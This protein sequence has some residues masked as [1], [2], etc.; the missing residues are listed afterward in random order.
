MK[1]KI[2]SFLEENKYA[3]IVLAALATL[4]IFIAGI[5]SEVCLG[6]ENLHYRLAKSIFCFRKIISVDPAYSQM[7]VKFYYNW[8][9]LWHVVLAF[10]WKLFGKTSFFLA[11]LYQSVYYFFLVVFT[12]LFSCQ[13][14]EKKAA[15]YAALLTA[16]IPMIVSFSILFYLDVPATTFAVLCAWLIFN[17]R[18]FLGGITIVLSYLL[19]TN[20]FLFVPVYLMWLL[21]NSKGIVAKIKNIFFLFLPI[22]LLGSA[23]FFWQKNPAFY[24]QIITNAIKRIKYFNFA[25]LF[26][27]KE[28]NN[29]YLLNPIDIIKY[30]GLSIISLIFLNLFVNKPYKKYSRQRNF[31]YLLLLFYIIG[32]GII[33][34]FYTDIRY[35]LPISP[36]LAMLVAEQFFNLKQKTKFIII[37]LCFMQVLSVSFYV[38]FQRRISPEVKEGFIFLKENLPK[39]IGVIYPE[40]AMMLE[41]TDLPI[42]WHSVVDELKKLFWEDNKLEAVESLRLKNIGYLVVLK[43]RVYDDSKFHH[44]GGYPLSFIKKI[45]QLSFLEP[46]FENGSMIIFK[47]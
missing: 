14:I 33:F 6:D 4:V 32:F 28:F 30:F 44:F 19:K 3:V 5:S 47:I 16:S 1:E 22:F 42:Y 25:N 45:S 43:S 27:F 17:N 35:I 9:A 23:Y 29:S 7:E 11:Q 24:Y 20:M 2:I 36:F 41:K 12:Y 37:V 40:Y 34:G 8:P 26:S 39:N 38:N 10:I 15:I 13:I 31:I 46:I 21:F 18:Y